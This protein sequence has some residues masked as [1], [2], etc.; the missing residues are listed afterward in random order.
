MHIH[1]HG[2]G[3]P[4]DGFTVLE[5]L[6]SLSIA[7]IVTATAAPAFQSFSNNQRVKAAVLELHNDL[8]AARGEAIFGRQAVVACPGDPAAGCRDSNEWQAGWIVFVDANRDNRRQDTE[9]VLRENPGF[10]RTIMTS[11]PGRRQFR[12]YPDGRSPGSNGS[13]TICGPGGPA[14]ARKLVVSNVGRIRRD[15]APELD[16]SL[17]P[18]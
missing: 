18:A 7:A 13:L 3:K 4:K 10:E 14:Q 1:A 17:C 15:T 6:V 2:T 16:E 5:L 8:A 12:F 9:K 11:S